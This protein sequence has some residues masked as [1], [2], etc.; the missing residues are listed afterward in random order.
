MINALRYNHAPGYFFNVAKKRPFVVI[1]EQAAT[2][3]RE[4]LPIK[5]AHPAPT[6]SSHCSFHTFLLLLSSANISTLSHTSHHNPCLPHPTASA[7]A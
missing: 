1:M 2:I 6:V 7:A 3:L 5:C 4:A